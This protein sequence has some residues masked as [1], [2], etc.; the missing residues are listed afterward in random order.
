MSDKRPTI[1]VDLRKLR[2]ILTRLSYAERDLLDSGNAI[3]A[4]YDI[5]A[6]VSDLDTLIQEGRC[7]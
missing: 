4:Y 6:V 2:W 5:Q 1:T 3:K 7:D